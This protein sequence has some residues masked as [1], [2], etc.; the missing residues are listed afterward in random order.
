MEMIF[1]IGNETASFQ[2]CLFSIAVLASPLLLVVPE[3]KTSGDNKPFS[4]ELLND[5]M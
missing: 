3:D 4:A 1:P 2:Q 5:S